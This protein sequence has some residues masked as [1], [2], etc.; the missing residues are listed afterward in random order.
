[1]YLT[2]FNKLNFMNV[3]KNS[4][5]LY[6]VLIVLL[7]PRT[8][9]TRR[10]MMKSLVLTMVRPGGQCEGAGSVTAYM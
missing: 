3:H 7:L 8:A 6:F 1:M 2:F 10:A 5:F 9:V 4:F